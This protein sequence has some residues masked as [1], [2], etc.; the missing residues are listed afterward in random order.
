[1]QNVGLLVKRCEMVLVL[2]F[3][4]FLVLPSPLVLPLH[5]FQSTWMWICRAHTSQV[6]SSYLP[7][8]CWAV[9]FEN[10]SQECVF[11]FQWE[12][13]VS[14][15]MV[16]LFFLNIL[17]IHERER[18]EEE[19]TQA[20]GEAGSTQGAWRGA[21]LCFVWG[22]EDKPGEG[23]GFLCFRRQLVNEFSSSLPFNRLFAL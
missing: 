7:R 18:E 5:G 2:F 22:A 6:I 4:Y 20:D 9:D 1:M 17:F 12:A 19:E 21:S 14:K 11:S 16:V 10:D 3:F 13:N 23:Q 15:D 8:F